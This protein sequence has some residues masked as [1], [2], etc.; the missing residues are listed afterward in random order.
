M[1][2]LGLTHTLRLINAKIDND[3]IDETLL[4][5]TSRCKRLELIDSTIELPKIERKWAAPEIIALK[6]DYSNMIEAFCDLS[7]VTELGLLS[8]TYTDNLNVM[9]SHLINL[10][11]LRVDHREQ[12]KEDIFKDLQHLPDSVILDESH[13]YNFRKE[14]ASG[15]TSQYWEDKLAEL[16]VC[17]YSLGKLVKAWDPSRC[18]KTI[19]FLKAKFEFDQI[20]IQRSEDNPE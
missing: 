4:S 9:G 14:K 20:K 18:K 13:H 11:E 5:I 2:L 3:S 19:I 15:E 7:K 16:E 6:G 10:K 17:K 8:D 1:S 12:Q